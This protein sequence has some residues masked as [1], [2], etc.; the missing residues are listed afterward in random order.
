MRPGRSWL[1]FLAGFLKNAAKG[2]SFDE[3]TFAYNIPSW[4]CACASAQAAALPP[5]SGSGPCSLTKGEESKKSPMSNLRRRDWRRVKGREAEKAKYVSCSSENATTQIPIVLAWVWGIQELFRRLGRLLLGRPAFCLCESWRAACMRNAGDWTGKI[6]R[7]WVCWVRARG[8]NFVAIADACASREGFRRGLALVLSDV[9]S[10]PILE[11]AR[12]RGVAARFIAPGGFRTKLDE[13]AERAYIEALKGA[14][15]GF[16]CAGR[17]HAGLEGGVF[18]GFEGAD[19][20]YSPVL[21]CRRF[22]DCRRGNRHW[23]MA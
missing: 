17:V 8:S 12:E 23:S 13:E 5:Q 1:P 19:R 4:E 22:R 15:R 2:I 3:V 11:R 16:D 7:K 20:E 14:R 9:E 10:A 18:A 21:T 6:P